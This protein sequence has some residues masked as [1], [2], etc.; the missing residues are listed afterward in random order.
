[1]SQHHWPLVLRRA[2]LVLPTY[3]QPKASRTPPQANLTDHAGNWDLLRRRSR[4]FPGLYKKPAGATT[5]KVRASPLGLPRRTPSGE[6]PAQILQVLVGLPMH[7][8]SSFKNAG[9]PRK[10]AIG[11]TR[12]S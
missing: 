2:S 8:K 10:L 7:F 5:R 6:E 1:M 12:R 4:N 3:R 9:T 11:E